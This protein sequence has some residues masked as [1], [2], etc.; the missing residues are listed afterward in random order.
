MNLFEINSAYDDGS[1]AL[2]NEGTL[3]AAQDKVDKT[4]DRINREPEQTSLEGITLHKLETITSF[5]TAALNT[6][7]DPIVIDDHAV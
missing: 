2:M 4:I 1:L 3:Y 6:K 7:Y 5:I